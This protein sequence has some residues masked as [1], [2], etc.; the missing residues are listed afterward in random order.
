MKTREDLKIDECPDDGCISFCRL[1]CASGT[2]TD[3]AAFVRSLLPRSWEH[4][5][6]EG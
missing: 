4:E 3:G 6:K 1:V 5:A 2:R